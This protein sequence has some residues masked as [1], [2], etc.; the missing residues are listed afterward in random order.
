MNPIEAT[1]RA[2][3]EASGPAQLA[4]AARA[5]MRAQ[6]EAMPALLAGRSDPAALDRV[7]VAGRLLEQVVGDVLGDN[8]PF[9]P[10]S[11]SDA[12]SASASARR[13]AT[14]F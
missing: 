7:R 13:L 6:R 5:L 8:S 10:E 3:Y 14:I 1:H 4:G 2:A 9:S 12:G 11:R